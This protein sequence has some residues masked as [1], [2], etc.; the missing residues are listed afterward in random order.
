MNPNLL[1]LLA[2]MLSIA[3]VSCS[4]DDT[5]SI[6]DEANK[7][8]TFNGNTYNLM[9]AIIVDEN[10][11]N[12]DPGDISISLFNKNSAEITSNTDLSDISYVNFKI[13]DTNIQNTTYSQID[14]YDIS[15]NSS[16]VNS[17]FTPGTVLLADDDSQSDV[18]AQSGSVTVTNFTQFNIVFTFTFTRNDGQVIT[19]SYDGNYFMPN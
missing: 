19:G 6:P 9:S 16:I 7:E 10:T 11:T 4:S 15:I 12:S 13:T 3:L 2:L 17:E 8:F 5:S 14:N 18:Y 1:R